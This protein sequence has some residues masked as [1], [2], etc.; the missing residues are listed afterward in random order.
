MKETRLLMGMPITIE[1]TDATAIQNDL[2]LIFT[3]FTSIDERFSTYKESS[4]ISQIN[5]RE[6][7][8]ADYSA[9]MRTILALSEQTKRETEG[10]FDIHHNGLLD[11]SGLVKGWAIQN[12]AQ[13]LKE[14]GFQHF[15]I[16]A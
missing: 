14:Q 13:I 10:Y 12:A 2:D 8:P 9:D 16:D 1:I 7:L 15:Y 4:E 11:P 3:Y 6:L 5:R